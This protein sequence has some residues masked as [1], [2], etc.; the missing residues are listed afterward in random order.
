[1]KFLA[2]HGE[3]IVFELTPRERDVLVVLLRRYPVLNPDYHRLAPEG[4]AK[5]LSEAQQMLVEAMTEQHAANRQLVENFLKEHLANSKDDLADRHFRVK[6]TRAQADWLLEVLN[7][8]RVGCW[9]RLG[10]P[11]PSRT[12]E[13]KLNAAN[14]AEFGT[15]ELAGFLQT[16]LLEALDNGQ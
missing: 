14:V 4:K 9:V 5:G 7:D 6:F 3:T 8:V 1:M 13:F 16:A 15:M 10:R 12:G 2:K 11:D